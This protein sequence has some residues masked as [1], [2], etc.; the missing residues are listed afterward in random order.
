MSCVVEELRPPGWGEEQRCQPCGR[1]ALRRQQGCAAAAGRHQNGARRA[2]IRIRERDNSNRLVRVGN[3]RK[4][5]W[6]EIN[7]LPI[8]V[9]S[10]RMLWWRSFRTWGPLGSGIYLACC[11]G[12]GRERR[13]V[14]SQQSVTL[15]LKVRE[16]KKRCDL[17]FELSLHSTTGCIMHKSGSG[18]VFACATNKQV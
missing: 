7:I 12:T 2:A 10:Q 6:T 16:M 8:A 9:V 18:G 11:V 5:C 4:C 13:L 17:T 14:Y 3:Y 1:P 15:R